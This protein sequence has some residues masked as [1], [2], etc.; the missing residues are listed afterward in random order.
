MNAAVTKMDEDDD[1]RAPGARKAR[2][3]DSS[4]GSRADARERRDIVS[5]TVMP[6]NRLMRF[7][8]DPDGNVVP[9][10]AAKLPGR[11]LGGEA[12]RAAVDTGV[13]EKVV[14]AAAQPPGNGRA[15]YWLP[16]GLRSLPSSL[17]HIPT[18]TVISRLGRA[19]ASDLGVLAV[20]TWP[21]I[22]IDD[23]FDK[24]DR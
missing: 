23:C 7:V 5:G 10:A 2:D 12:S 18:V 21:P 22:R 17:S 4:K 15:G 11:G 1:M 20:R 13:A 6:E 16:S 24:P 14:A 9:D 19:L 8:A 3:Q